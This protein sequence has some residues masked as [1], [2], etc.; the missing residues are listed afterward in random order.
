MKDTGFN[1][2]ELLRLTTL[3]LLAE[4]STTHFEERKMPHSFQSGRYTK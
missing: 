1:L 3:P 2:T 4:T